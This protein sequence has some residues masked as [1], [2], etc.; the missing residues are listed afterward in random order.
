[1]SAPAVPLAHA[2]ALVTYLWHY[3]LARLLY[4]ELVRP[5]LHGHVPVMGVVAGLAGLV[6]L[7]G[8]RSRRRA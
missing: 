8:R 5:L 7:L 6:L 3:T 2:S 4:D 1:M